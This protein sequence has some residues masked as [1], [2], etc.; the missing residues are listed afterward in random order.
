MASQE[1]GVGAAPQSGRRNP[2]LF[3]GLMA[4]V[5]VLLLGG[6]IAINLASRPTKEPLPEVDD[7]P[8]EMVQIPAGTF[9]MGS[10]SGAPDEKPVHEVTLSSFQ[11]DK[12]EVTNGQFAAFVQATGYITIAEQ[13]PDPKRYPD[14][15]PSKLVPG[16]ALFVPVEAPLHGP[17]ETAHPPWWKYQPGA[18]WRHPEGPTSNLDGKRDHPVVHIAWDDAMAYCKWAGKRLPTEA[19]WEYAA[20]GGLRRQEFCWGSESQGAGGV[21]RANTFQG[22]FPSKD[23]GADGFVGIAPVGKYPAN[24]YGL[25]DMSG[26]VWEWC[27]DYYD[28]QYYRTSPRENPR[29]PTMGEKEGDQPLR[30]RRGGSFLCADS[31][32]RRYLPS[33]RDSNPSDSGAI[34]TGFRCVKD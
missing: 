13:K 28:S 23:T 27:S 17:W 20:R 24:G 26:N 5:I 33:A 1:S 10:D 8:P 19:E 32:C 7:R 21:W 18:N 22:T 12:T 34:H 15:A 4:S 25:F 16:S 30:V 29:G 3:P 2:W 31:Y 14:V 9:L 6:L 11:I